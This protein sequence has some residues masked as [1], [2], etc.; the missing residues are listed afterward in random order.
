MVR[1]VAWPDSWA[2]S[3]SASSVWD[4]WSAFPARMMIGPDF[5]AVTDTFSMLGR[6]AASA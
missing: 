3:I 5:P 4:A 1:C 2:S 6:G